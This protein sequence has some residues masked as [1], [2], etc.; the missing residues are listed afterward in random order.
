M[1]M[2]NDG[3]DNCNDDDGRENYDENDDGIWW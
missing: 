3:D 2:M 1:L